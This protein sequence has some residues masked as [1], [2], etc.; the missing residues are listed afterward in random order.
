MHKCLDLLDAFNTKDTVKKARVWTTNNFFF[1]KHLVLR[2]SKQSQ[3]DLEPHESELTEDN[4]H[5]CSELSF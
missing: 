4:F 2:S 3:T 5:F 1:L